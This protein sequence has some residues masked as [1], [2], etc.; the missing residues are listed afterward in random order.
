MLPSCN[1]LL[2]FLIW[3]TAYG[4][5]LTISSTVNSTDLE[6]EIFK[7]L[8][9]NS[10]CETT[11][12]CIGKLVC[13]NGQCQCSENHIWNG[14]NCNGEKTF[15]SKCRHTSECDTTLF[16]IYGTCQCAQINYWNGNICVSNK[17]SNE[18]CTNS[19]ECGG[20]LLCE[21]GV[22]QCPIDLF[23]N[24]SKCIF[25]HGDGHFC[26]SSIGCAENLECRESLCQCSESEYWDNSRCSSRKSVNDACSKEGECE[27]TL[28]CARSV[29]QCA[30]SDYWTGST[31]SIKTDEYGFCNSSLECKATLQCKT[32]ICVCCEQDFWN[33]QFCERKRNITKQC[34]ESV[35]CQNTLHC[36]RGIC[37]C[38][39]TEYWTQTACAKNVCAIEQC[40]NGGK[41]QI[42]EKRHTCVCGDGYLGDKCQYGDGREKDFLL[43]LHQTYGRPSP[44]ILP[45]I[46]RRVKL[47][48]F[49]FENNKNM[50]V[51]LNSADNHYTLDSKVLMR[52]GLHEAGAE[53]HSDVPITIYGFLFLRDYSEGFFVLPTRYAST[54]YLIPSFTPHSVGYRS[55]FSLSSVYSNTVIRIHFK[56][57]DGTIRYDNMQYSNNQT[58]TLVLNKY[59]T[60]QISHTTDLTGTLIIA[61]KPVVVVSGNIHNLI[62]PRGNTQPFTEMVL[63]TNQLDNVYII[64]HLKYRLENTVR[65]IAVNDTNVALTNG[66]SRT[67][68][69]LK[70]R[71]FLDY[72]HTTISYVSSA[73]DVMVH[74]YPHDLKLHGDAFMMTIPGINQ[75]LYDY[76]FMVPTDF[77]S[78]IS[79][80]VPT[81]AVDGFVLDDNFVNLKNI[82]SIVEEEH[83]FSSFSI[84][85]AS[86]PHHITHREKTRFGLW[87]YGNYTHYDTY[88][89]P[90][91]MAFKT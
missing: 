19:N 43:I 36:I 44:R 10:S 72:L 68:N 54:G 71:D 15:K 52:D 73:S 11:H 34:Q 4:N 32:N 6:S 21:D 50:T 66:N 82:F 45:T 12:Q 83:H 41:C 62:I 88:G 80:T 57:K 77:E 28:Y 39:V 79:I 2:F 75:Y 53:I 81:D 1:M 89:Y 49:Y 3:I 42:T 5:T 61:S 86:G 26:S 14:T 30:S 13:V 48:V 37:Q 33:G 38:D 69:V 85:I 22:C 58:L 64:P 9:I 27:N 56:I 51:T 35:Q 40:L 74:I 84:P 63:P 76:D 17:Q 7:G 78:F 20:K 29:C 70:S 25:K 67:R 18:T 24:G 23:W 31:C 55:V 60:F 8:T 65:I 87:V 59:T 47:S 16:C 90:A 91:G 46:S